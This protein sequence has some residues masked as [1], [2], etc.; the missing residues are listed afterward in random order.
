MVCS[1]GISIIGCTDKEVHRF[2]FNDWPNY[3][4]GITSNPFYGDVFT[5]TND[6]AEVRIHVTK[7]IEGKKRRTY[8]SKKI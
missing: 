4:T 5:V 6:L 8:F 3:Y 7:V 2:R 1:I